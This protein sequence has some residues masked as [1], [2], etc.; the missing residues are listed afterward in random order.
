MFKVVDC[1]KFRH[2][3]QVMKERDAAAKAAVTAAG[4][5]QNHWVVGM[6]R[7]FDGNILRPNLGLQWPVLVSRVQPARQHR[8]CRSLAPHLPP[9]PDP[10]RGRLQVNGNC[11]LHVYR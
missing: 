6:I 9:P 3:L 1:L 8:F 7:V 10:K 4:E 5:E 2:Y 11:T